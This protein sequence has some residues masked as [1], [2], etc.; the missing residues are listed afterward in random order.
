[1]LDPTVGLDPATNS[2]LRA[3][4]FGCP[5]APWQWATVL[6]D[7]IV[8]G[9]LGPSMSRHARDEHRDAAG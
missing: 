9:S 2:R 6:E 7:S 8:S 5:D 3:G 4:A 1:M